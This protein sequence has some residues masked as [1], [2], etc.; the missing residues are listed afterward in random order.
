MT[1]TTIMKIQARNLIISYA[2]EDMQRNAILFGEHL[3]YVTMVL[4]LLRDDLKQQIANVSTY[5]IN[6]DITDILDKEKPY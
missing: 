2:N 3:E 1:D 6:K 4:L 5:I